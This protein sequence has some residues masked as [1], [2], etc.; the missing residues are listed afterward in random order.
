MIVPLLLAS[1]TVAAGCGG[2]DGTKGKSGASKC[3]QTAQP[4]PRDVS[5]RKPPTLRLSPSRSYEARVETSCG[6]FTIA[7]AKQSPRTGGSFVTLARE[8]FYDGLTFHRVAPGFVIQGGDP[9]GDGT[10]GAG[11]TVHERVPSDTVYSEGDVAMGKTAT[12]PDGTSSSQFFV[13]TSDGADLAPDSAVLGT[14]TSGL[15]VVHAIEHVPTAANERPVDPVV[16]RR[17]TIAAK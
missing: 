2:D 11:Y 6:T 3:D 5:K 7:L 13:V 15:G 4:V 9:R 16:I 8:G 17:I 1:V 14:V 12:E 10:G